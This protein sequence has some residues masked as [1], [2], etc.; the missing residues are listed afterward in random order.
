MRALLDARF[1]KLVSRRC[2]IV[3]ETRRDR[4]MVDTAL[5]RAGIDASPRHT[6][7]AHWQI[8]NSQLCSSGIV[9]PRA[10]YQLRWLVDAKEAFINRRSN[11]IAF[12]KE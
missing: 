4:R 11:F 12:N 1:Y 9:S 7:W 2:G 10:A 6:V 8:E 3:E 5:T